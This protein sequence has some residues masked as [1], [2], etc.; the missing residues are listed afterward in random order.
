MWESCAQGGLWAKAKLAD[1]CN[2]FCLTHPLPVK[3][4]RFGEPKVLL[5]SLVEGAAL[6]VYGRNDV[7][8][9]TTH[10]CPTPL[11]SPSRGSNQPALH[12]KAY[13]SQVHSSPAEKTGLFSAQIHGVGTSILVYIAMKSWAPLL[14]VGGPAW[15]IEWAAAA[16]HLHPPSFP[17]S[18]LIPVH[19]RVVFEPCS[20]IPH[21]RAMHELYSQ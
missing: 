19:L 11:F 7:D 4:D 6:C 16:T 21:W 14:L 8:P 17:R 15:Q 5:L 3:Q 2:T 10:L 13:P 12:S 20:L 1:A 18:L 9:S